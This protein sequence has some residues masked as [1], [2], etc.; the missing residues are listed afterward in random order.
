[1]KKL[2]F[3]A[4]LFLAIAMDA[5]TQVAIYSTNYWT[6]K[7]DF[8]IE[9]SDA[10]G[11]LDRVWIETRTMDRLSTDGYLLID[12]KKM[13]EFLSF[14]EFCKNKYVEWSATAKQNNVTELNKKI[15]PEKKFSTA[16]AFRYGKWQFDYSNIL[17]ARFLISE[18]KHLLIF[19]TGELQSSSNQFMKNDGIALV[20]TDIEE[21]QAFIDKLDITKF[22]EFLNTK[23]NKEELFK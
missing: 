20:F 16:A 21:I 1:M 15:E 5:Q 11:K 23:E 22:N 17:S 3:F 6:D 10:K 19:S 7:T 2:L 4:T 12:E 13:P 14:L 18:G 8:K 9:V